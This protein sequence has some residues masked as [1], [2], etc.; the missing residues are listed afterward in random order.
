MIP[1]DFIVN[2]NTHFYFNIVEE[3]KQI[4][5]IEDH[6]TKTMT[7]DKCLIL[8]AP[9]TLNEVLVISV[10]QNSIHYEDILTGT[11]ILQVLE[12]FLVLFQLPTLV[13]WCIVQVVMYDLSFYSLFYIC[14]KNT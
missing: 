12:H 10:V 13:S 3:W 5:P 4:F 11:I 8:K 14:F 1:Q 9:L 2:V 7:W 6:N